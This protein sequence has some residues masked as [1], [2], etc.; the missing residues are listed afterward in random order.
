MGETRVFAPSHLSPRVTHGGHGVILPGEAR[1]GVRQVAERLH[2]TIRPEVI[3]FQE[4]S[5][6]ELAERYAAVWG[7]D[8]GESR[9][10]D[11]GDAPLA[12][13][14]WNVGFLA[15]GQEPRP[16]GP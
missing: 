3:G 2:D 4:V 5:M 12:G 13:G 14:R 6:R 1:L 7:S 11:Q 10:L 8:F 9:L 16:S 15:G